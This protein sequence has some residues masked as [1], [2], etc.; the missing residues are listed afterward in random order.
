MEVKNGFL[1]YSFTHKTA[2][3]T[4]KNGSR[5]GHSTQTAYDLLG[6]KTDET[7]ANGVVTHTIYD[8]LNR[9]AAVIQNYR[10][11]LQANAETNVRS[12]YTYNAVGNRTQ[13]IGR[14]HV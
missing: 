4:P 7:D 11:P 9:P 14:A 2:V 6:N 1:R 5:Q 13:E 10:P 12:E 3:S 8:A